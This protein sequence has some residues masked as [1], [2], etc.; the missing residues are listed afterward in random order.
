MDNSGAVWPVSNIT[1]P[2][3]AGL[4]ASPGGAKAYPAYNRIP[5]RISPVGPVG[6]APPG[7][8]P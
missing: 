5:D 3:G 4:P 7:D 6:K 1:I 8:M 2:G